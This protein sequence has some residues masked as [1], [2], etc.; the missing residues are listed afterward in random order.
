AMKAASYY[1]IVLPGT[2]GSLKAAEAY[3]GGSN[4]WGQPNRL[5][6]PLA[7]LGQKVTVGESWVSGGTEPV[8]EDQDFR[9][10]G[11]E[12]FGGGSVAYAQLPAGMAFDFTRNGYAVR[13]VRGASLK[14]RVLWNPASFVLGNDQL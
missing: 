13:R 5:Y 9:I 2:A 3:V 14:V 6:F 1:R 11:R 4:G 8:I 12:D 10:T 7:D